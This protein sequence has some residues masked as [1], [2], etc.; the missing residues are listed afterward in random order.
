V[1]TRHCCQIATR[2]RDNARRPA[3]RLRRS[4][5]IAGWIIP[6]ATLVLLPKCPACVAAYVALFSGVGIS[7]ASASNLWTSLL[8]LCVATLLSLAVKRLY[9]LV[10]QN[11]ALSMAQTQFPAN[12]T[13]EINNENHQ[14]K[15]ER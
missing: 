8:I 4:G 15:T 5:E 3:S 1:N 10:S 11:K 7:V 14:Q 6:S 13:T 2:G 12:E 9:R